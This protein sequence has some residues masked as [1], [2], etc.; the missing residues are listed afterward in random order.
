MGDRLQSARR[1]LNVLLLVDQT[2]LNHHDAQ[3]SFKTGNHYR[4]ISDPG[5]VPKRHP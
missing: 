4:I 3:D 2:D 1:L 5:G